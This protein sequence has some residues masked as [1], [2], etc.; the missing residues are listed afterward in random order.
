MAA[1]LRHFRRLAARFAATAA[2]V[3]MAG[4]SASA[5]PYSTVS[6]TWGWS[7][8]TAVLGTLGTGGIGATTATGNN[9][10][11]VYVGSTGTTGG[12]A[13]IVF[14]QTGNGNNAVTVGGTTVFQ[15]NNTTAANGTYI[16]DNS[17]G[18]GTKTATFG[19]LSVGGSATVGRTNGNGS[20]TTLN[21]Q[22]TSTS[23]SQTSVTGTTAIAAN[24]ITVTSSIANGT[25]SSA[26]GVQSVVGKL[27]N[28]T[29]GITSA[30]ADSGSLAGNAAATVNVG[31]N[32][33]YSVYVNSTLT[34]NIQ[35]NARSTSAYV[36][37]YLTNGIGANGAISLATGSSLDS[38]H[39]I[40]IVGGTGASTMSTNNN[41]GT[42]ILN[43]GR[44]LSMSNGAAING[45]IFLSNSATT[46][47]ELFFAGNAT[48]TSNPWNGYI[49]SGAPE[50]ASI[51]AMGVG[52]LGLCG[53]VRRR[54]RRH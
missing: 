5:I 45:G 8:G 51:A 35:L 13:D 41:I 4:G 7:A 21:E 22:I 16:R 12:K 15:S 9:G 23:P 47:S 3:S 44:S 53:V 32:G 1:Y 43:S 14:N 40:V 6:T 28:A 24:N 37:V 11:T 50:P 33:Y 26:Q 30:N 17:G 54:R 31:R 39:V 19:T 38:S 52:L 42:W 46:A 48:I 18:T 34:Q 27:T 10:A 49:A 29:T 25:A 20:T 36:F 2:I